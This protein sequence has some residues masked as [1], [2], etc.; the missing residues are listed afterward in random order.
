MDL[1]QQ[2]VRHTRTGGN[3]L[4]P[5]TV[6]DLSNIKKALSQWVG[7]FG[8]ADSDAETNEIV[9]SLQRADGYFS[10]VIKNETNPF[11]SV[12]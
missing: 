3:A 12:V 4:G 2:E 7:T 5:L 1:A 8:V 11:P 6:R 10:D 9:D